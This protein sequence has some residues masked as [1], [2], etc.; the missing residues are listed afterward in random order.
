M[1]AFVTFLIATT[2]TIALFYM[3]VYAVF[4]RPWQGLFGRSLMGLEC[5]IF[6][7]MGYAFERRLVGG[8][9]VIPHNQLVPA[10]LAYGIVVA[11]EGFAFAGL[12][13]LLVFRRG[14][15]RSALRIRR[16]RQQALA[17]SEPLSTII[18]ALDL[19]EDHEFDM[20]IAATRGR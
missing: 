11:V 20:V 7:V 10:M 17:T 5:G 12:W 18:S 13:Q 6:A 16:T 15:V 3:I 19:L 1:N 8:S 9:V 2:G 4:G 14:G